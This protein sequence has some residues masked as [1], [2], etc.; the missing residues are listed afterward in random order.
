MNTKP[1]TRNARAAA[2]DA[3]I[4]NAGVNEILRVGVDRISL[5]EVAQ[6]AGLTHGAAYARF[7]DVSELLIELWQS[8]LSGSAVELL[9]LSLRAVEDRNEAAIAALFDRIRTP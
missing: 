3:A 6:R 8:R 2:N 7:E 4:A 5:R 1:R 9:E